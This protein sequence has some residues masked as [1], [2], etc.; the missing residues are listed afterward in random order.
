MAS[1][2]TEMLTFVDVKTDTVGDFYDNGNFSQN[3][4]DFVASP[5]GEAQ[6][7]S[8]REQMA[9]QMAAQGVEDYE[10]T[11]SQMYK[12]LYHEQNGQDANYAH[13]D[14]TNQQMLDDHG[15]AWYE[16]L[17]GALVSLFSDADETVKDGVKTGAEAVVDGVT[18]NDGM[19]G[20]AAEALS[21]R[22]Q[23]I[24]DA[25][26]GAVNGGGMKP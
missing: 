14:V 25:V 16:E 15:P 6:I 22:E 4:H 24:N 8:L 3:L 11:D 19:A 9:E 21:G 18:Q 1:I 12:A 23:Q 7:N 2:N 26:D 10:P 17:G 20:Q 5:V 13:P